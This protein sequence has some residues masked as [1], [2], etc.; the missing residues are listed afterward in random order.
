MM[1]SLK[2]RISKYLIDY[3]RDKEEAIK[4]LEKKSSN[5]KEFKEELIKNDIVSEEELL[6]IF[7]REYKI[8]YLDLEKYHLPKEN[9]ELL[10]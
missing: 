5:F 6:I 10:P 1:E 7:S 8:P 4:D 3:R 2:Q 9:K